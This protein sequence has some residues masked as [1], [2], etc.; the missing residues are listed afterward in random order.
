MAQVKALVVTGNGTNCE[1][2]SAH[3]A[4]ESGAEAADIVFFSYLEADR[5]R[6]ADYNFLIF[7]GGFLDGDDLGAAQAAACAGNTPQ[8]VPVPSWAT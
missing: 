2:E 1:K 8:P 4:L 7:P 3:A 5:T 6:L